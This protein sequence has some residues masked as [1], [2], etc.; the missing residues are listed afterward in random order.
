MVSNEGLSVLCVGILDERPQTG[1][2][3]ENV[4]STNSDIGREVVA[5]F[6]ED[7]FDLLL[8]GDRVLFDRS[9]S[10]GGTG[11]RVSLPGEE[12]DDS[13]VRGSGIDETDFGGSVVVG[14]SDVNSGSGSDDVLSGG[15]IELTNSV[16]E[17]SSSV[18]NTL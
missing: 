8:L 10:I 6:V 15:F 17:R 2:G 3:R 18:D 1:P 13:T 16:R 12:E 4:S 11:D 9:R 7:E 14:K 5:N